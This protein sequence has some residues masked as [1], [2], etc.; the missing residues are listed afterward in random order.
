MLKKNSK[1]STALF[2]VGFQAMNAFAKQLTEKGRTFLVASSKSE[3]EK[4]E[5]KRQYVVYF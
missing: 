4:P 3:Q 5:C 2:I 1:V